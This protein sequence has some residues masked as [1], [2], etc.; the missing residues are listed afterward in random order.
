VTDVLVALTA[1]AALVGIIALLQIW[2]FIEVHVIRK[3]VQTYMK[4]MF[5]K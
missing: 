3:E 2:L 5:I 1:L 4:R